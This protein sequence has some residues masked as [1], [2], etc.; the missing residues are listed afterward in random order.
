MCACC[1]AGRLFSSFFF[2]KQKTAYEM[3]IR[4]WSSDVCSSDLFVGKSA[5]RELIEHPGLAVGPDEA[6]DREQR[7]EQ[8]GDPDH[9][10]AGSGEQR[11]VGADREGKGGR[12]QQEKDDRQPQ[13]PAAPGAPEV[14]REERDQ[15]GHA[16]APMSSST[17]SGISS[18]KCDASSSAPPPA[19]C[20]AIAATSRARALS[21]MPLA[22]S[23]SS[24]IGAPLAMTRA[25]AAR[26]RDRNSGV[27]GTR[28][29][30][31]VGLGGHRLV[32]KTKRNNTS[33]SQTN[34]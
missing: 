18:A 27:S 17:S 30:G 7:R 13:R 14:A 4:D 22:G 34:N 9:A 25:L 2:F 15:R 21:S 10:A 1:R 32:T 6:V 8:G 11:R 29:S 3:R 24:Q 12:D 33:A 31:R 5:H 19:R 23:S 26:L 20:R 28:V 16:N